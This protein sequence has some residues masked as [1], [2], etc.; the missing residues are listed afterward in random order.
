MGGRSR[1]SCLVCVPGKMFIKMAVCVSRKFTE[2][3]L[4]NKRGTERVGVQEKIKR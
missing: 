1:G 2:K 3:I 4:K